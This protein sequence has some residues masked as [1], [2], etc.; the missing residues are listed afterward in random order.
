MLKKILLSSNGKTFRE[1]FSS[2]LINVINTYGN[3][4]ITISNAN[5]H[6]TRLN[7]V[8]FKQGLHETVE[9]IFLFQ[10]LALYL[11]VTCKV[12]LDH[13]DLLMKSCLPMHRWVISCFLLVR[14]NSAGPGSLPGCLFPPQ[15]LCDAK[16][17]DFDVISEI[18]YQSKSDT[19]V[20]F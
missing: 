16:T 6:L 19:T 4:H 17:F 15:H 3:K 2:F 10:L 18:W 14:K 8:S 20:K 5:I 9:L 7:P 13:A 12:L 11:E 1:K